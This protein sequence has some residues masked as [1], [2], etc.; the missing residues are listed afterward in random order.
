MEQ[1]SV[2]SFRN[3]RLTGRLITAFPI[4]YLHDKYFLYKTWYNAI[5]LNYYHQLC[6]NFYRYSPSVIYCGINTIFTGGYPDNVPVAWFIFAAF[7]LF[8]VTNISSYSHFVGFGKKGWCPNRNKWFAPCFRLPI[9][10]FVEK[11]GTRH[12]W[13]LKSIKTKVTHVRKITCIW[14]WNMKNNKK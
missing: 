12:R 5:Y 8:P 1:N 10:Y 14:P 9:G 11:V 4:K 6:I 13:H 3:Y 7:S 2:F